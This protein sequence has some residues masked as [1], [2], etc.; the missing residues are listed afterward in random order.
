MLGDII[1]GNSGCEF[2]FSSLIP[3]D[4]DLDT[5]TFSGPVIKC[6]KEIYFSSKNGLVVLGLLVT[7]LEILNP[8]AHGTAHTSLPE[9]R[10]LTFKCTKN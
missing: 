5:F 2:S 1:A 10:N 6:N 4:L 3:F 9:R 8:G 7:T